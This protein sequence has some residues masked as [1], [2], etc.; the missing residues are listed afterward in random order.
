M[1]RRRNPIPKWAIIG[2]AAAIGGV[3]LWYFFLRKKGFSGGSSAASTAAT[4]QCAEVAATINK[5]QPLGK[6]LSKPILACR[7]AGGTVEWLN[8]GTDSAKQVCVC[9]KTGVSGWSDDLGLQSMNLGGWSNALSMQSM[10][11][12]GERF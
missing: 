1:R 5:M 8:M 11:L 6:M 2:G 4:S 9:G 7:A 3:A 10:N 12:D